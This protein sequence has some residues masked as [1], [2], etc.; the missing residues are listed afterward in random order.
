MVNE[1]NWF[2]KKGVIFFKGVLGNM[3]RF[4]S[5]LNLCICFSL[6]FLCN[7]FLVIRYFCC[8]IKGREWVGR[9]EE[10][11]KGIIYI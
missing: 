10:V 11:V 3:E 8:Y 7:I 1:N 4:L 9:G 2:I 5:L 6:D